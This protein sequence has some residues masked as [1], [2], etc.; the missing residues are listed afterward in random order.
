MKF[1]ITCEKGGKYLVK[2]ELDS[3]KQVWAETTSAVYNWAKKTYKEGDVITAEYSVK[4]GQYFVNRIEGGTG[5]TTITKT[6][7]AP[8]TTGKYTC[9]DC[10]KELKDDKYKKCY[11]C[12]KKNPVKS[13]GKKYYGKSPE[14]RND[15]RQQAMLKASVHAIQ[16]MTGQINDV[17]TLAGMVESLY[18]R[19]LKKIS[20]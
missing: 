1:V 12:N 9:A 15:I 16:V 19:F 14:E 3:G 17:D 8:Q 18:D 2:L 7:E 6:S 5:K 10:G 13:T 20:A 4:N 11:T